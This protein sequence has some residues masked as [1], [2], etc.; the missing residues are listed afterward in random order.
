MALAE[1]PDGCVCLSL[2]RFRSFEARTSSEN[3]AVCRDGICH[4]RNKNLDSR[5]HR[6]LASIRAVL[7]RVQRALT[8]EVEKSA[9]LYSF[10][11]SLLS[12]PPSLLL[13]KTN[14]RSG[15]VEAV[16]RTNHCKFYQL[17]CGIQTLPLPE[18]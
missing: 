7:H 17:L 16:C 12:S 18:P 15:D 9:I 10:F 5:I 6:Y 11:F 13:T 14:E 2:F 4:P 3:S 8:R 1:Q